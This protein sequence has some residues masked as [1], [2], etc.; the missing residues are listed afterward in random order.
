MSLAACSSAPVQT[1]AVEVPVPVPVALDPRLTQARGEPQEP[2][3]HCRD[4]AG[5]PSVCHRDLVT[6]IQA[7]REWGR[8]G[9]ARI[10]AIATLQPDPPTKESPP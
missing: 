10:A 4:A 8:D 9:W 5:R 1:R 6:Y 3:W 7:L 2:G